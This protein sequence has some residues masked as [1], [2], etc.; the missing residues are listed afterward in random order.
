MRRF[1]SA[2]T[3]LMLLFLC[4]FSCAAAEDGRDIVTEDGY[5]YRLLADGTAML[6]AYT[7]EAND[8]TIPA[9]LGGAP[10]TVIGPSAFK[11]KSSIRRVEIPDTVTEIGDSAF[12][13]CR[14]LSYIKLP[15]SVRVIGRIPLPPARS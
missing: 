2:L 11:G 6:V 9:E 12:F 14:N 1:L 13:R 10:L 8:L 7:G 3:V 5:Q 15:D 4:L